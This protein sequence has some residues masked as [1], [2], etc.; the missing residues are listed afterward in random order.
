MDLAANRFEQAALAADVMKIWDT[1]PENGEFK[2]FDLQLLA[3]AAHRLA[4][5]IQAANDFNGKA[6]Q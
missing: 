4:E 1:C 6:K 3:I 5:L 2:S